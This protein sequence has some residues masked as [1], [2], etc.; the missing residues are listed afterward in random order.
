MFLV[1]KW[2]GKAGGDPAGTFFPDLNVIAVDDKPAIPMVPGN[3]PFTLVLAHE[4]VHYVLHYRGYGSFHVHDQHALLNDLVESTVI[5][6]DLQWKM[7][8]KK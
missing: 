7:Q 3:D 1:G 2:K 8:H 6:P 5:V 4:L